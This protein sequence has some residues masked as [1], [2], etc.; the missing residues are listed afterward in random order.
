V[1]HYFAWLLGHSVVLD[2][3]PTEFSNET[4][5]KRPMDKEFKQI[6]EGFFSSR[7]YFHLRLSQSLSFVGIGSF[8]SLRVT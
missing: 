8:H 4:D 7:T 3:S 2:E 5:L 6:M 1:W